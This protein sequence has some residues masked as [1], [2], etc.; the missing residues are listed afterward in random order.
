MDLRAEALA[1]GILLALVLFLFG[2]VL[3][4][5]AQD[6]ILSSLQGDL[7][8]QFY[9]W[10]GF[11]ASMMKKGI[12][13]L[14][15]PYIFG[16]SPFFAGFQS[17]LLYPPNW[18]FLVLPLAPA[19]NLSIALHFFL[20]GYFLHRWLGR[21]PLGMGARL[22]GAATFLLGGAFF[23]HL[24]PG[25]L[26]NLCTMAWIPLVFERT[27]ALAVEGPDR[28]RILG[29]TAA[30]ALQLLSGHIQY[31]FYTVLCAGLYGLVRMALSPS[32]RWKRAGGLLAAL[33]GALALTAIQWLPGSEA[34]LESLRD[35]PLS[36]LSQ[37]EFSLE[38]LNLLSFLSPGLSSGDPP[39]FGWG[40]RAIWWEASLFLGGGS[41]LLALYGV[42]TDR[43]GRSIRI[44]SL[45]LV[46]VL[47][48]LG[49]Y[50]PLYPFLYDHLPF[51]RFFRGTYKFGIFI[52]LGLCFL[53]AF[54]VESWSRP[55]PEEKKLF[56]TALALSLL[57]LATALFLAW[58]SG[59]G[60]SK[61]WHLNGLQA[62]HRELM[63]QWEAQRSAVRVVALAKLSIFLALG[64]LLALA[65]CHLPRW[66]FALPLAAAAELFLFAFSH[67]PTFDRQGIQEQSALVQKAMKDRPE[68]SRIYWIDHDDRALA[69]GIPDILGDDPVLPRR[70]GYFIA[71][72][73][74][75][76]LSA[77][78]PSVPVL[79]Q[80]PPCYRLLRLQCLVSDL[81]GG[82]KVIPVPF[83]SFPRMLLL[84]QW[85]E[86]VGDEGLLAALTDPRFQ[87]GSEVLLESPPDPAP[88]P[89][90]DPGRL[91]WKEW[92]PD[93]IEVRAATDRPRMLL[94]TDNL[95]PG[96]RAKAFPDSSQ[97]SYSIQPGDY[98]FR[99]VPLGAGYHHFLF[100]Y[101][102]NSFRLGAGITLI[103]AAFGSFLLLIRWRHGP[104]KA[105]P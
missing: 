42:M 26:P 62:I 24:Y 41:F 35:I 59:L 70:Y 54:G 20:A 61:A 43:S 68:A 37:K 60:L 44:G 51:F 33:G 87:P 85:R 18:L 16:G 92:D 49:S 30:L 65:G 81:K 38:P 45:L 86:V 98:L 39:L 48:A 101:E 83:P 76:P 90:K 10:R 36:G 3:F 75:L 15:D 96:W 4:S 99:A 22:S 55:R 58:H 64:A 97:R 71:Y 66:R 89:G 88:R 40:D 84:D 77:V 14:W 6:R 104:R 5:P 94:M 12:L 29:A 102:P 27:E 17:A 21:Y 74:G 32:G 19:L 67:R 105:R 52:H 25:H 69:L 80:F 7:A 91:E 9:A 56:P 8:D 78:H 57:A 11:G 31:F 93:H 50:T 46:P 13:P 103:A 63:D 28:K 79:F 72:S 82:F 100:S 47:L 95:L 2:D 23:L 1:A 53:T 73:Q 34:G